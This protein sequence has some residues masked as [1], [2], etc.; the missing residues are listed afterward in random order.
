MLI[1]KEYVKITS[2]QAHVSDPGMIA[3]TETSSNTARLCVLQKLRSK[4]NLFG[5]HS[6]MGQ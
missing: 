2:G 5:S 1:N 6:R 3:M 4:P